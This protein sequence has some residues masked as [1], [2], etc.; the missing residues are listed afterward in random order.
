[1]DGTRWFMMRFVLAAGSAMI[2]VLTV[3]INEMS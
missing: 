1:M 3:Y 2:F